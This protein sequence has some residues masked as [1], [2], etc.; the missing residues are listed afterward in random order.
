M[1]RR[2]EQCW[3]ARLCHHRRG[4]LT[5][6]NDS[7][8]RDGNPRQIP[9]VPAW[10]QQR[11]CPV[12]NV[13]PSVRELFLALRRLEIY[14]YTSNLPKYLQAKTFFDRSGLFLH[15]FKSKTDP[16]SEDYK[17]GKHRLL[18]MAIREILGSVG[19]GSIF[20]VEDTSLRIEALSDVEDFP[21]LAVKEWFERTTFEDLDKQ[22]GTGTQ[23]RAV[24]V[25]S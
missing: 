22:L 1:R 14:F 9:R 2:F 13:R 10:L 11:I 16:Y 25:K 24:V 18:T 20:F 4:S 12:M 15:Q 7:A 6:P 5:M 3:S 8:H 21:G 17:L 19:Q 23:D